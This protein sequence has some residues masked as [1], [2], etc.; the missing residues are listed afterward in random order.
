M[1]LVTVTILEPAASVL[2]YIRDEAGQVTCRV[3][4]LLSSLKIAFPCP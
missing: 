4:S 3:A 2:G 1:V